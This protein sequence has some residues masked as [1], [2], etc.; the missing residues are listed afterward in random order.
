MPRPMVVVPTPPLDAKE[1]QRHRQPTLGAAGAT[2]QCIDTR[3]DLFYHDRLD[4]IV[5]GPGLE[6]T[7]AI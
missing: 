7:H 1:R 4:D 3:D 2:E 6:A 5:V